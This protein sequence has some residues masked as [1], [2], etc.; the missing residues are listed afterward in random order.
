MQK[1]AFKLR[2]SRASFIRQK[3]MRIPYSAQ[4]QLGTSGMNT[5]PCG[6]VSMV[7]GKASSGS[8]TSTVTRVHTATV[9]LLGRRNGLRSMMALYSTLSHSFMCFSSRAV[10]CSKKRKRGERQFSE[11]A[12]VVSRV[13]IRFRESYFKGRTYWRALGRVSWLSLR[14]LNRDAAAGSA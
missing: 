10:Q 9:L 4:V 7:R 1:T 3:P 14:G 11:F 8:Q 13:R 5:F 2:R 6:G 12:F